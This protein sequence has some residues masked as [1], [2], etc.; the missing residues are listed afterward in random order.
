MKAKKL[1][2]Q[3]YLKQTLKDSARQGYKDLAEI[4]I[5]DGYFNEASSFYRKSY[6]ES[7]DLVD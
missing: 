7:V 3:N 6:Q 5:A 4:Y 2:I 1:E